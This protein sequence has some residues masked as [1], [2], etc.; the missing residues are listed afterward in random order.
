MRTALCAEGYIPRVVVQHYA[1]RGTY[2]EWYKGSIPRVVQGRHTQGG[3]PGYTPRD[4]PR[5]VYQAILP[6][7]Y[8]G[9]YTSLY[10]L[11]NMGGRH[12]AHST[13]YPPWE[14]YTPG[15]HHLLYHPGYT[16]VHCRHRS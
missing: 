13:T 5:E 14:V 12:E 16:T 2:P 3:I 4:V 15:I 1:Q 7:M 8:P 9:R 6:R 10:Y 11:P